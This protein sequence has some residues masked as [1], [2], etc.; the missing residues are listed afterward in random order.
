VKMRLGCG[1]VLLVV[2]LVE[3]RQGHACARATLEG[4]ESRS[5]LA[6]RDDGQDNGADDYSWQALRAQSS[7]WRY[8]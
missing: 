7:C 6:E 3:I 5:L 8:L 2:R 4:L 1:L